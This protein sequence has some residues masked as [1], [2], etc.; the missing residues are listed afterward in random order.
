MKGKKVNKRFRHIIWI[1]VLNMPRYKMLH[2]DILSF[3]AEN[4]NL[5]FKM[6]KFMSG[7]VK[8]HLSKIYKHTPW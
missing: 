4:H 6:I 3:L 1:N 5:K 7:K 2:M 8:N